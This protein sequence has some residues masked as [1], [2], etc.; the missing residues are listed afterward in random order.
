MVPLKIR[1]I[2]TFEFLILSRHLIKF[3]VSRKRVWP[4]LQFSSF[5]V[6]S[7]FIVFIRSSP[8]IRLICYKKTANSRIKKENIEIYENRML[9]VIKVGIEPTEQTNRERK[10]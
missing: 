2:R 10:S 5:I 1:I 7:I 4:L 3:P 9:S 6:F 8:G